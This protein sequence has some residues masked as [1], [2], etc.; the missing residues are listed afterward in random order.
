MADRRGHDLTLSTSAHGSRR[1]RARAADCARPS[2]PPV[3]VD[4][5]I[6]QDV[7]ERVLAAALRTG[8]DFAEVYAEDKRSTSA[9]ARRRPGR[10]GHA[11]A[12][13]AAPASGSSSARPPASPTP[14]TCPSAACCAAAEAAAAAARQRRR[15]RP[16]VVALTPRGRAPVNPV[17]QLPRRGAQGR[18]RSSCCARRRRRRARPAAPIAQ[19]SAGYGDSR[20]RDPRGQHRRRCWPSDDQVRTLL[21]VSVVAAGDTGMQTG[22]RVDRPH[23]RLRAVRPVDVEELA[24]D[25]ARQAAHQ[26]RRPPGAVAAR[27]PS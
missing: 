2:G 24:R 4:R 22:F 25:A 12:A 23:H 14:P 26:A 18:P 13:T 7:L 8:G 6:D 20:K 5:V 3:G 15:R 9:G 19:V 21:R 27:C 11:A 17:E 10:A 16:R 1:N